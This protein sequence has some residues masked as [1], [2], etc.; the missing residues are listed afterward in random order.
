MVVIILFIVSLLGPLT[1]LL[2]GALVYRL[3]A[4]HD[5]AGS[6]GFQESFSARCSETVADIR[7]SDFVVA[8]YLCKTCRTTSTAWFRSVGAQTVGLIGCMVLY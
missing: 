5:S 2:I 1:V 4:M 6:L 3:E 7:M 8:D